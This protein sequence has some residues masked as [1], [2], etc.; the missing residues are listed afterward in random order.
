VR[1]HIDIETFS[2][3]N[4]PKVG[5]Y[6]YAEHPSTDILCV[7]YAFDDGPISLWIPSDE[8]P[9]SLLKNT[10]AYVEESGGKFYLKETCP[11]D[12]KEYIE[13]GGICAAHKAEFE[14]TLLN[15]HPGQS[16]GFP[17]TKISQ[18]VCTAAKAAASGLPRALGAACIAL[19]TKHKKQE[20]GKAHMMAL[21][22]PRKKEG[23]PRWTPQEDPDRFFSLYKYCIDDVKAERD[24]D[25]TL[26]DLSP[27]EQ[28]IYQ[29][30]QIINR[31]GIK[32]DQPLVQQTL[33]L[34]DQYKELVAERCFDL[35]GLKPTQTGKLADWI[36]DRYAIDDLQ[37]PTI[38]EVLA[39]SDVPKDVRQALRMRTSYS[40]KA[41]SKLEA[42]QRVVC[43]DGRMHGLF[44]Y[45]GA[46]PGR[47]SSRLVQL[48]NMMRSKLKNDSTAI[49]VIQTQDMEWLR[50]MFGE[51]DLMTV[52]GSVMRGMLIPEDGHDLQCMDY[53]SIEAR[54]RAWLADDQ[55]ALEIYRTHGLMYEHAAAQVYHLPKDEASLRLITGDRRLVGKISDLSLGFGGGGNAYMKMAKQHGVEVD[56]DRGEEIKF[57][58]RDANPKT[59]KL[60]YALENAWRNAVTY[61]GDVFSVADK[62]IM[63]KVDGD[64]MRQR[65]PSGRCISYYK[66]EAH[67]GCT[68]MG[69]DTYTRQWCRTDTYGGSLTQGCTEAIGRDIMAHGMMNL[70]RTGKYPILGTVHDEIIT[71]PREGE[72]SLEEGLAIMCDAPAWSEGLPVDAD[73]FREK[74][75]RK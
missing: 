17:I 21:S 10:A 52:F 69:I 35:T 28:K 25:Q 34:K 36:R 65:M 54:I 48:Q 63:F 49:S 59:V 45:W 9:I 31:R 12:L 71:E 33:D 7:C 22:K 19:D 75:Y 64:F 20:D 51:Y 38:K 40:M 44:L 56:F 26:P 68:Y 60:W 2:E 46:S 13:S 16:R 6:R 57:A 58:W 23:S 29:L 50:M 14:R 27:H 32:L 5:V 61:P 73:G 11:T 8:V 42:M 4:L 39:R 37:A 47:W 24:I 53:S 72:G 74:R 67:D 41:P 30:D 15:G 1:C 70:E 43:D 18:W 62:K 55:D 66:P 3:A